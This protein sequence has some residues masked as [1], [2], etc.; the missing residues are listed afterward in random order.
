[1]SYQNL[2]P[3]KIVVTIA[4]LEQ[5]IGDR[6]PT[7]GLRSVCRELQRVAENARKKSDWIG[8]PILWMRFLV[9]T[10]C[11]LFA[12]VSLLSVY[13]VISQ[14]WVI[15]FR[16]PPSDANNTQTM[17]DVIPTFEAELNVLVLIGG[18]IFFLLTLESRYK[19][20]RAL[21]AIDELRSMAHIIDMHQL[22][23]DPERIVTKQ[24]QRTQASPEF[25][26]TQFE[27]RRY[28]DYCSEMLALI[29]KIAAI[30]V[31]KFD[32]SVALASA[33]EV[34]SLTTGLSRKIWQKLMVLYSCQDAQEDRSPTVSSDEVESNTEKPQ[35]NDEAAER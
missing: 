19:R 12:S 35:P 4:K 16:P 30:Y 32:D 33:S 29:G 8:R 14:L 25:G 31:Q 22:T 34:E 23:K 11:L 24:S 21:A 13:L 9:W 28:L 17:Q 26:F 10:G 7:S 3:Q 5:R 1:M 2:D 6:F 20:S 15:Y 18:A 27:L